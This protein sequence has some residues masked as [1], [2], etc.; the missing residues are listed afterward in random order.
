MKVIAV[1]GSNFGDEGK[2]LMT[3]YFSSEKSIVVRYNGGSQAGHT[4]IDTSGK[5]HVFSHFGSGS[6]KGAATFLSKYFITNPLLW[7]KEKNILNKIGLNPI[8]YFDPRS[9]LTLPYD[10]LINQEAEKTRGNARHGS[11]GCGIN[12]TVTRCLSSPEH[13]TETGDVYV[14][15]NKRYSVIKN[16]RDSYYKNRIEQLELKPDKKFWDIWNSENL[17]NNFIDTLDS[18]C[19]E[20]KSFCDYELSASFKDLSID[21]I[22][23]EGAQGLLL[24]EDHEYFPHVTRS[25][26]GLKNVLSLCKDFNVNIKNIDACYVTRSYMTRHGSGPFKSEDKE[27][28]YEDNTN[29]INEFQGSLRFGSFDVNLF[30]ETVKNDINNNKNNDIHINPFVSVTH[31]DQTED[32]AYVYINGARTITDNTGLILSIQ[33]RAGI[34]VSFRSYGKTRDDILSLN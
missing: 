15:K 31:L 33:E 22:V 19:R 2:G 16:I 27:L 9:L 30:A 20:N 12:E 32:K 13:S 6:F 14:L 4:V 11:C 34:K 17:L 23:F 10:M 7:L 3:D 28:K 8:L 24:D 26:T 18:F 1:I 5:R 25:K 29:V 21:N